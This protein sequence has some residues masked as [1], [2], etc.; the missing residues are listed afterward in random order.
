AA[1]VAWRRHE[2]HQGCG[3]EVWS[4][5][6]MM[7]WLGIVVAGLLNGS[8]TVPMKTARAWKFEH[9]WGVFSVLAMC[10]IPWCGVALAVPQ[11]RDIL[12]AVPRS[13]LSGLILL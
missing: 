7:S 8:F 10:V 13:G 2:S 6:R 11:W 9:I 1:R 5:P 3:R 4:E 12:A